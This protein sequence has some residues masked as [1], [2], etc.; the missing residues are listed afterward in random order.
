MKTR[1][2]CSRLLQIDLHGRADSGETHDY[3]EQY[4]LETEVMNVKELKTGALL[5]YCKGK[6][7]RVY[8]DKAGQRMALGPLA[9]RSLKG[10]IDFIN[11]QAQ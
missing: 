7:V 5:L 1:L 2:L 11:F 4:Q 3:R 10:A 9:R 6:E 8:N